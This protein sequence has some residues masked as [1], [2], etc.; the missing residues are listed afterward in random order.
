[1]AKVTKFS[2]VEKALRY[3]YHDVNNDNIKKY[4]DTFNQIKER[5]EYEVSDDLM[6]IDIDVLEEDDF[7]YQYYRIASNRSFSCHPWHRFLNTKMKRR[8]LRNSETIAIF[9]HEILTPMNGSEK[10]LETYEEIEERDKDEMI[11]LKVRILKI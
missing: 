2:E 6:R 11:K 8:Y 3:F 9:L 7:T 4:E 10:L 5:K 1:M